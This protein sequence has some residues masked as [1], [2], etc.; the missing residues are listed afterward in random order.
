MHPFAADGPEYLNLRKAARAAIV[1]PAVLAF[2]WY[3]LDSGGLGTYALFA[4]FV[5]LVFADYGGPRF[6]RAGAY[7]AMIL[8]GSSMI[9]L[10][11]LLA[12]HPLAAPLGMFI[13]MF[14]A[15][16]ATAFGGARQAGRARSTARRTPGECC[17][18]ATTVRR[19]RARSR[20]R[21]HG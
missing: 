13:V 20:T 21:P 19:D 15:T 18:A 14:L 8:L 1:A 3:V 10:G 11:A 2:G 4:A 5:G 6:R 16:F 17:D 7:L 12:P 9:V